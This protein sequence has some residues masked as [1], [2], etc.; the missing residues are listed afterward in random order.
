GGAA[1]LTGWGFKIGWSASGNLV[2]DNTIAN[3][4]R[5][6]IGMVN[7]TNTGAPQAPAYNIKLSRNLVSNTA[8]PAIDLF[9]VAGPDPNDVGDVD[10]GANTLL[11]TPIIT[12]V[13][14]TS[15]SGTGQPTATVEVYAVDRAVGAYGLPRTYLG[16]AVVAGNGAWTLAVPLSPATVVGA[17]QIMPDG[18][19]SEFSPNA[20]FAAPSITS[21]ASTSFS[22]GT[23]GTF[24]VTT[25]GNPTAAIS[26]SGVLPAGVTFNDND[27]GT[28]TLAGTPAL[29]SNGS[30]PLTILASNGAVPS[31]T[32]SFTLIVSAA[33]FAAPAITSA[34]S[35]TLAAGAA[36]TFTVTSTGTP[37]SAISSTGALP[38]GVTFTDSGNGTATLAGTPAAGSGGT[39]PITITAANGVNPAA[40]QSFTLTVVTAP[41]ITSANSTTFA[42]GGPWT[43]TVTTTGVPTAAITRSGAL[44]TGVTF[45]DNGNGTGTLAGTP[46]A[47][48][49][50]TYPITITAA[51]GVAPNATQAFTLTVTAAPA[52]TS[53]NTA[54]YAAGSAFAFTV[55]TTGVPTAAITRS[56][57]LPT[58]VTFTD[59]RNGTATL[60]GTPAAGTQ[61]TY[62]ITITAANG[63]APDATQP[64]TLIVTALTSYATDT[65]SRTVTNGWATADRGGVWSVST[66]PA[67]NVNGSMGTVDVKRTQT[68]WANLTAVS[69]RDVDLRATLGFSVN[70]TGGN[71]FQYL[72]ARQVASGTE[73]RA[74][75]R[76]AAG[77]AVYV[78]LMS[79]ASNVETAVGSEVLV[80]GITATA[81]TPIKARLMVTG[82]SPTTLQLK[83]WS[84]SQPEPGAWLL[85]QSSSAAALQAYGAIGIR[86]YVATAVAQSSIQFRFDDLSALVP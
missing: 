82:V 8:G 36:G 68:R 12:S 57:A 60:G 37:V 5:G 58:G 83:V 54:S 14:T 6:G 61:G 38:A 50:G 16:S 35:T 75:M 49:G 48:S 42:T 15:V 33:V 39:Y 11:N 1:P 80:S 72:V 63:V 29:G 30:Y 69:A 28:A 51:N 79:A 56:G 9:G 73:Y 78:Q 71:V 66:L 81:A 22:A 2:E 47:G 77:G 59:N 45:T 40:T 52:I 67:F 55:T 4:A 21:A 70:P 41:A 26:K 7:T 13:T 65:F 31:A 20:G 74:K 86:A 64:F 32:Q 19:T 44:P 62:P 34:A 17:L 76:V 3:A 84:A 43:F 46:A 27:N 85:T 23:L 18:N 24:T 10:Q 53:A 25:T